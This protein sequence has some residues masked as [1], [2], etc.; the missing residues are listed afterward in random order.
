M[1][2]ARVLSGPH[3]C[4]QNVTT[5]D[6]RAQTLTARPRSSRQAASTEPSHIE[7]TRRTA[8]NSRSDFLVSK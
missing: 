7:S 8:T 4:P 5:Q 2:P 1:A 3:R 6:T